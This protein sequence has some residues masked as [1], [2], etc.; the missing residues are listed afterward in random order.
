MTREQ[1]L[2]F[3]TRFRRP[4]ASFYV[5]TCFGSC[6]LIGAFTGNWMPAALAAPTILII[7]GD[8]FARTVEKLYGR[9]D[10]QTSE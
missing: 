7:L 2:N 6:L 9:S 10:V 5:A 1:F 4:Y 3:A 8:G